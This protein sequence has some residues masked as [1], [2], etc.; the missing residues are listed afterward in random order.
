M[1]GDEA[2]QGELSL[3]VQVDQVREVALGQ[4]VA[5]PRRL[6][7]AAAPEHVQQRQGEFHAGPRHTHQNHTTGEI[8]AIERS[9][10]GGW[11]SDSVDH[12]ISAKPVGELLNLLRDLLRG[13]VLR[14]DGVCGAQLGGGLELLAVDVQADDRRGAR[15]LRTGDRRA[16][17]AAQ[18]DHGD[19]FSALHFAGIHGSADTRH[20]AAAQQ[21]RDLGRGVLGDLGALHLVHQGL[22]GEGANAEGRLE[23]G[24]VGQGHLLRRVVSGE[25]VLRDALAAGAALAAHRAPVQDHVVTH[26]HVRHVL[27]DGTDMP[28]GLMAQQEREIVGDTTVA[29]GEVGVADAAGVDIDDDVIRP[30][31]G[32]DDV[33][34]LG[35]LLGGAGDDTLHSLGH[36]WPPRGRGALSRSGYRVRGSDGLV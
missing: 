14:V 36:G 29:V 20:D 10:V 18:A 33:D 35:R 17:D 15:E 19:R 5:V 27:A 23:L 32:D 6:Q 1:A 7:G 13:E 12:H 24:A 4:A 21:T 3:Q 28:C 8:T 26:R 9:L 34:E 25:T 16:A 11:N 22:F 30:R 31:I 2:F